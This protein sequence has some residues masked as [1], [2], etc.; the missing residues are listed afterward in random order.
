MRIGILP[1][2]GD[3]GKDGAVVVRQEH[4]AEILSQIVSPFKNPYARQVF[5]C[6][7][8]IILEI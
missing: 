4:S 3:V 8:K 7:L 1:G 6:T 5:A 2:R